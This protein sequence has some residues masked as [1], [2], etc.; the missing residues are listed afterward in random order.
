LLKNRI[1]GEKSYGQECWGRA[2]GIGKPGQDR[3]DRTARECQ[4]GTGR[5]R[6]RGHDGKNTTEGQV[7]W[8][9]TIEMGHHGSHD[10]KVGGLHL[11]HDIGYDAG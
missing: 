7:S 6:K 4:N 9:R 3:Q 5:I 1:A 2:A 10:S 8:D 11:G